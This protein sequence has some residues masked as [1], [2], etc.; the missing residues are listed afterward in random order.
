MGNRLNPLLRARGIVKAH[1]PAK[2]MA[3]NAARGRRRIQSA[4]AFDPADWVPEV[5]VDISSLNG[6]TIAPA[7][8]ADGA[9]GQR[10]DAYA[11]A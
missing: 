3:K 11:P 8:W 9:F 1:V 6:S 7:V 2:A 5:I 10:L 4:A